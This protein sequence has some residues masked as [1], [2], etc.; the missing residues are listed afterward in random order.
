MLLQIKQIKQIILKMNRHWCKNVR[1]QKSKIRKKRRK[2][3]NRRKKNDCEE[4]KQNIE[5]IEKNQKGLRHANYYN[6]LQCDGEEEENTEEEANKESNMLERL[7]GLER[8]MLQQQHEIKAL[9]KKN[10]M[11]ENQVNNMKN[12]SKKTEETEDIKIKIEKD[13]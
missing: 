7:Q 9:Q 1:R 5:G 8:I 3:R 13:F 10:A 11:L 6:A 12:K 2:C 4:S